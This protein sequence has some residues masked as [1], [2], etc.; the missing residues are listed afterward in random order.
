MASLPSN[1][2]QFLVYA[3]PAGKRVLVILKDK[4]VIV[5]GKSGVLQTAFTS[6]YL[7]SN[8]KTILEG[9]VSEENNSK[10]Y[11]TDVIQWKGDYKA[12]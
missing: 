1:L 2:S 9:I 11:I 3:R 6:K 12:G 5:V 4:D 10:I 7:C 8:Q